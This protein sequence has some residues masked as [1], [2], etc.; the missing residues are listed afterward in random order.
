M[1]LLALLH[2]VHRCLLLAVVAFRPSAISLGYLALFHRARLE[3]QFKER[4]QLAAAAPRAVPGG[5][6]PGSPDSADESLLRR[7]RHWDQR[8]ARR[9]AY[10][11]HM[12]AF[13]FVTYLD[14]DLLVVRDE[15]G[16][17]EVLLR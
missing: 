10:S 11:Q 12:A 3:A 13:L 9:H 2:L 17:P 6:P 15:T 4:A 1:L 5:G 16:V 7:R 8:A 14:D